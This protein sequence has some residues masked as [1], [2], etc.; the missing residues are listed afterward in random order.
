MEVEVNISLHSIISLITTIM[1]SST[2]MNRQH[3]LEVAV[4]TTDLLRMI[5]ADH[6]STIRISTIISL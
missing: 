5:D 2:T 6:L 1:S 4:S 3:T